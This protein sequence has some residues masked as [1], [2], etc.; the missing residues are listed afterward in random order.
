MNMKKKSQ[1]TIE[2]H[3]NLQ[4]SSNLGNTKRFTPYDPSS[5]NIIGKTYYNNN[6][7]RT[8][9]LHIARFTKNGKPIDGADIWRKNQKALREERQ[10]SKQELEALSHEG[11]SI[12]NYNDF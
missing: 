5:L 4:T 9:L 8:D 1:K 6:H 10:I 3:N 11:F 7:S 12:E 2:N